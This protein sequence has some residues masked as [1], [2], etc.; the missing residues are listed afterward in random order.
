M[1]ADEARR[2]LA[3]AAARRTLDAE[4]RVR[5]AL[6]ELD[7]T[8]QRSRSLPSRSAQG[9]PARSST[10]MPSCA[11][12]SRRCAPPR[13]LLPRRGLP[14]PQRASDTRCAPGCAPR[15]MRASANARRS[16]TC[17]R[18]SRS[19]TATCA[20]WSS[21][22]GCAADELAGAC[23]G[24]SAAEPIG[25]RGGPGTDH[26]RQRGNR[27]HD[28]PG[29]H[30]ADRTGS[31]D[32][33]GAAVGRP[34]RRKPAPDRAVEQPSQVRQAVPGALLHHGAAGHDP[35]HPPLPRFRADQGDRADDGRADGGAFRH[36]HP[37]DHRRAARPADRGAR[38][39][40]QTDQADR[41]RVGGAEGDQGSD[42][43]PV[44]HRGVDVAGGSDLQGIRRRFDLGRAQRALPAGV[45]GVGHRLQDRRHDRPSGR[46][47]AR[48]PR[49]DQSRAAVHPLPGRRQR[50]LLPPRARPD[51]RGDEDPGGRP[52]ADRPLPG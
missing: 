42:G 20:S 7:R 48:Q 41:R 9:F 36:R 34:G 12:R 4:Q 30:R 43:V 17:A 29:G 15:W 32:R 2:P 51:P 39:G 27:L 6:R 49:A 1:S 10:S 40:T 38:T 26:L 37:D 23:L 18:S 16:P 44:R 19:R 25:A 8:G 33:G 45:R 21:T 52:G 14:V 22:A 50:A 28:R 11:H 46:D 13:R 24:A 35:G 31:A 47:P 5:G 3:D